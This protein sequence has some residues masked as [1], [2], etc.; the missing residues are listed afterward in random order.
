MGLDKGF[1]GFAHHY[2]H[3]DAFPL[4]KQTFEKEARACYLGG[5]LVDSSSV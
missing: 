2:G 3:L 5:H 4:M 1:A